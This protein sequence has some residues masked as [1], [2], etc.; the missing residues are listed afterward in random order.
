MAI[1]NSTNMTIKLCKNYPFPD[2]SNVFDYSANNHKIDEFVSRYIDTQYGILEDIADVDITGG[3]V[4]IAKKF[5]DSN[6]YNYMIIEKVYNNQTKKYYCF[7]RTI[8]WSSNLNT[9][10]LHFELDLWN[11]YRNDLSFHESYI[12]REH[13]QTDNKWTHLVDEGFS[14]SQYMINTSGGSN[15]GYTRVHLDNYGWVL[16]LSDSTFVLDGSPTDPGSKP[17][18]VVT[19]VAKNQFAPLLVKTT[20]DVIPKLIDMYIRDG[21]ES[22]ILGVYMLPS[23]VITSRLTESGYVKICVVNSDGTLDY[24][25]FLGYPCTYVGESD[26]NLSSTTNNYTSPTSFKQSGQNTGFSPENNKCYNY[27][28]N[29]IQVSNHLGKCIDLTYEKSSEY[30]H[31]ISI[32]YIPDANINGCYYIM[33][34]NYDGSG[35][36]YNPDYM[37]LSM[38][39][40]TVPFK[41][42]SYDSWYASNQNT[43]ANQRSFIDSDYAFNLEK[44][45]V[46]A[47]RAQYSNYVDAG[48]GI[49]SQL[50]NPINTASQLFNMA[51]AQQNLYQD[52]VV[53][54]AEMDYS[55]ASALSSFN[56]NL[57]DKALMPTKINGLNSPNALLATNCN[58]FV[59]KYMMPP[60]DELKS[61]DAYFTKYGYKV[62]KFSA[63][64]LYYRPRFDFK[65]IPDCNISGN[66]PTDFINVIRAMFQRGVTIWH[67]AS[68]IFDYTDNTPS[69]P[70]P[71]PPQ[72]V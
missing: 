54:K 33:P 65:K 12:E 22:A 7:I 44:G 3:V 4:R 20:K 49:A 60:V 29:F 1:N 15:N 17:V 31:R 10:V 16:A 8:T 21:K 38:N 26:S 36:Y 48:V 35:T 46:W 64:N 70:H 58:E 56:S 2:N 57:N 61:I 37:L 68:N 67:D 27:P 41:V 14:P 51:F 45:A 59:V 53:K 32:S 13:V 63:I 11:T 42:S 40:P 66:I 55:Y 18:P 62:N 72:P 30:G 25:N 39:Y 34:S 6:N 71:Q 24:D 28:F 52:A 19:Q 5:E 9:S 47:D 43:L 69:S 23:T 50:V